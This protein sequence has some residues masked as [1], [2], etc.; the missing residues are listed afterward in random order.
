MVYLHD[1]DLNH[2]YLIHLLVL[3]KEILLK[4]LFLLF[5]LLINIYLIYL[6]ILLYHSIVIFI[7]TSGGFN[8]HGCFN[9]LLVVIRFHVSTV[10]ISLTRLFAL[11][12]NV[13]QSSGYSLKFPE[14]V[15][16]N[17]SCSDVP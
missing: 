10:N 7:Y 11:S 17:I 12:D 13:S 6:E 2:E 14:H 16:N 8:I 3:N 5:V 4:V 9:I 1:M 15:F